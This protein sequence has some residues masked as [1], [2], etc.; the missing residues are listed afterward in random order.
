MNSIIGD[1]AESH[2]SHDLVFP[3]ISNFH[4]FSLTFNGSYLCFGDRQSM[5]SISISFLHI[6]V[7]SVQIQGRIQDLPNGGVGTKNTGYY[8]GF[9]L[10]F[11][12]RL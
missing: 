7:F 9:F 3:S 8:L 6:M 1:L 2:Y 5:L 10:C 11:L 4:I 12:R